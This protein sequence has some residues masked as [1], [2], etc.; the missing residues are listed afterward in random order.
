MNAQGVVWGNDLCGHQE[1][2]ELERSWVCGG[3]ALVW[4]CGGSALGLVEGEL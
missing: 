1:V 3:S 4:V 2:L